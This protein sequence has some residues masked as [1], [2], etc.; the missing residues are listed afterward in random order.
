MN[1]AAFGTADSCLIID[2]GAITEN[3]RYLDGLSAPSV[4]TAAMIKANGY[5]LGADRVGMALAAAGCQRFFV[6]S[7]DE[8][9]A[10]RHIFDDEGYGNVPITVLHGV[11]RGQEAAFLEARAVP[12]LNDLEQISRW[13]LFANKTGQRLSALIHFD[14]GMTRLGLDSAQTDWLIENPQ[15]LD[16]LDIAYVMSHLVSAELADDPMNTAQIE[17]F[18]EIKGY[19]PGVPSSLA[20]SGGCFLGANFHFQMTR[21]GIALYG[22]DP[23]GKGIPPLK[24]SL[25]WQARILQIRSAR[26]GERVGYNG[27]HLLDRESRIAT[28]GVG[29]ADGYRRQLGGKATVRIGNSV[30]PVIGRVSMD[31][32]TVDVTD[33]SW[34]DRKCETADLIHT[35]YDLGRMASDADTISYE[36]MTQLGTRPSRHYT[37]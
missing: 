21:P 15:A 2:L 17:R 11:H 25:R 32:I 37:V 16:G 33:L 1:P 30:A 31:S 4:M 8:A 10:Q 18:S 13:R 7:L 24:P 23:M 9:I 26:A 36:I 27:T 29:Y 19:F 5:G 22:I 6:A 12:V 35:T 34:D 28:I 3:W 14:T 20:N